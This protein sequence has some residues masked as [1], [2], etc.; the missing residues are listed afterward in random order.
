LKSGLDDA[1]AGHGA[2]FLLVGEPGIGKSRLADE[3]SR[4]ARARGAQVLVGRCWEAGGA[5]AYWPWVQ[6][7]RGLTRETD[8]EEL[9]ARLRMGASELVQLLPEL[10]EVFPDVTDPLA[11]ESESARFRLFEAVSTFLRTTAEGRPLVLVLDDLHAADEPSCSCSFWPASS[12]RAG[13]W[14]SAPTATSIRF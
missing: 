8:R 13:C 3:L 4:R 10:R 1:F 7:L 5:P 9:R 2:L 14:S 12:P 6:S 11:P